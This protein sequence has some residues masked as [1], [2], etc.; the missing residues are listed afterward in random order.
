INMKIYSWVWVFVL[1][2]FGIS[3]FIFI[4]N[5]ISKPLYELRKATDHIKAGNFN[6]RLSEKGIPE[7]RELKRS[8]NMMSEE[9]ETTQQKLLASEKELLWKDLSRILAHEIK[10][11]L[12]PIRLALERLEEKYLRDKQSFQ[13]YFPSALE[14]INNEVENLLAISRNFS[15]FARP[16]EP[17]RTI[18]SPAALIKEIL[19]GY[20]D[21]YPIETSMDETAHIC[22]DRNHFYQ[23][24][25]NLLQN[26]LDAC[27]EMGCIRIKLSS[28]IG[29]ILLVLEDNGSGIAPEDLPRIFDPYFT[30]KQNGTGL[31]LSVVKKLITANGG[32]I[33]VDS[34]LGEGTKFIITLERA[35]EG[36][37]Y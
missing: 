14:V 4:V 22:F 34:T 11:P 1:F 27:S 37:D 12:T 25:T 35:D 6:I 28:K 20:K 9:L 2:V 13:E 26:A 23:I 3:I 17:D 30:K 19:E 36:I 10:N 29:R 33:W 7:L 31:G 5:A 18:F 21:R 8:F 16:V 15:D 32:D 24:F